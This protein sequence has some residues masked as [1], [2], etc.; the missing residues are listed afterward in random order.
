MS[1]FLKVVEKNTIYWHQK[2]KKKHNL[3]HNLFATTLSGG[4]YLSLTHKFTIFYLSIILIICH[5]TDMVRS[6]EIF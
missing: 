1:I 3:L 6:C 5:V 4:I 2:K